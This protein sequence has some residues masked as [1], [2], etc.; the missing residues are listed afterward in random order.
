M[1]RGQ[2]SEIHPFNHS[3]SGRLIRWCNG[4]T[5]TV[6]RGR[7]KGSTREERRA[8]GKEGQDLF[9]VVRSRVENEEETERNKDKINRRLTATP[10]ASVCEQVDWD[11]VNE[12]IRLGVGASKRKESKKR[13]DKEKDEKEKEKGEDMDVDADVDVDVD[14]AKENEPAVGKEGVDD[15][16]KA[17]LAEEEQEEEEEE[18]L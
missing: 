8:E 14:V 11:E 6:R 1:G 3:P 5:G 4:M 17:V 2:I 16:S 9:F 10:R 7:K 13:K 18:I 12:K 15:D